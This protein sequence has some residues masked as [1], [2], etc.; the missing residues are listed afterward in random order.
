MKKIL[1]VF[2][3]S[4]CVNSYAADQASTE[5]SALPQRFPKLLK[6]RIKPN[7]T[8]STL[9]KYIWVKDTLSGVYTGS[10]K[11]EYLNSLLVV[12]KISRR[13]SIGDYSKSK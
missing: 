9:S 4:A 6:S 10:L 12:S 5:K 1:F 7:A 2:V 8:D 13:M 3:L 11:N